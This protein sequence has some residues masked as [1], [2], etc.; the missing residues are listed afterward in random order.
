MSDDRRLAM[1]DALMAW[2]DTRHRRSEFEQR[3]GDRLLGANNDRSYDDALEER[4]LAQAEQYA[5]NMYRVALAEYVEAR[6][7]P[8]P[9]FTASPQVAVEPWPK[10]SSAAVQA[11]LP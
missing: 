1:V 5:E 9:E 6:G 8:R 7:H 11:L 10:I 4:R 3:R 2:M